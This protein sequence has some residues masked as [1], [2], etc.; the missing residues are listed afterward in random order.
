MADFD[1]TEELTIIALALIAYMSLQASVLSNDIPLAISAGLIG[2]L[3]RG[4]MK[5]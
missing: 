5:K 4:K 2:Y 3:T 1:L